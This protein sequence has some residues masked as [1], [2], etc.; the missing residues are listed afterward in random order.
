MQ[1]ESEFIAEVNRN[2]NARFQ[3]T[4]FKYLLDTAHHSLPFTVTIEQQDAFKKSLA[5]RVARVE[6]AAIKPFGK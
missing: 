6:D 2:A 3:A 4:M 5:E 1:S